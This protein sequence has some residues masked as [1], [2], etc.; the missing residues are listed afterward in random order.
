MHG[1]VTDSTLRFF[2]GKGGDGWGGKETLTSNYLGH[3][4]SRT[5]VK[6]NLSFTNPYSVAYA[7]DL[8]YP[9]SK[10][11]FVILSIHPLFPAI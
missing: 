9:H 11:K 10:L 2:G 5:K 6:D 4:Y 3:N 7:E 1:S 8:S